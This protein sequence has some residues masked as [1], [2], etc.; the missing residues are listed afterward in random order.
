MRSG[1]VRKRPYGQIVP[2]ER[3]RREL[4]AVLA[5]VGEHDHPA[6]AVARVGARLI[7]PQALEDEVTQFFGGERY[8]KAADGGGGAVYRATAMSRARSRRR[9]GPM[10]RAPPRPVCRGARVREPVLGKGV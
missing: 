2:S 3:L 10:T 1:C 6:E 9:V 5:G 8:A 7:M 4:A